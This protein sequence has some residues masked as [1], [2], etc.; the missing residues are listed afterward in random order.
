MEFAYA[1]IGR[2]VVAAQMFETAL[3]PIFEF[4]KIQTEPGYLE[5][6]GGRISAGSFKFPVANIVK[7]LADR[8]NIASD[9]EARLTNYVEDRN[10]LIHRWVLQ[11]GW[12]DANDAAGFD[13]I[14]ELANRVLREAQQ[15]TQ[16]LA[17]YVL[18]FS[19]PA[20]L[21]EHGDE[22]KE[23]MAQLFH[24]AHLDIQ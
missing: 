3:V 18:R 17:G 22:Y 7:A 2:A 4:F 11:H 5:E 21:S 8:G 19:E 10:T 12:P 9:L 6:T 13:P 1:A 15:L 14:V 23:R 20:W 24:R 16:Q